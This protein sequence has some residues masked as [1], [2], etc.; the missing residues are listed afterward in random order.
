M[1]S[2][3]SHVEVK[4]DSILVAQQGE[5]DAATATIMATVEQQEGTRAVNFQCFRKERPGSHSNKEPGNVSYLTQKISR[6]LLINNFG[7]S[8]GNL[9]SFCHSD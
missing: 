8:S 9:G 1:Q 6:K 3:E 4:D 7:G 5:Q 2:E